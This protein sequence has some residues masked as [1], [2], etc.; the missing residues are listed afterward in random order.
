MTNDTV[1]ESAVVVWKA[2]VGVM[3]AH[4]ND[5][6]ANPS[7]SF[8]GSSSQSAAPTPACPYSS[9]THPASPWPRR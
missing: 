2:W 6:R 8:A 9:S 4:Y 1:S 5:V 3:I 7:L